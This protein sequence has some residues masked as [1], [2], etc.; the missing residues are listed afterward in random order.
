M[1]HLRK[2]AGIAFRKAQDQKQ[3]QA[4]LSVPE[5]RQQDKSESELEDPAIT[6]ITPSSTL[7][8]ESEADKKMAEEED[9]TF[10]AA[11]FVANVNDNEEESAIWD[12]LTSQV[13]S[14]QCVISAC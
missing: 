4:T 10:I 9:L 7:V 12:R 14:L 2:R 6:P 11:F 1:D 5:V 3:S 13:L 8:D